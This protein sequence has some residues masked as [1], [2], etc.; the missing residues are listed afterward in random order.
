MLG[1]EKENEKKMV[2]RTKK[3]KYEEAWNGFL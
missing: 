3:K 1:K 2:R